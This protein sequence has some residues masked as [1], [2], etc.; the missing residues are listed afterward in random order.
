MTSPLALAQTATSTST[1]A[2][3]P[4]TV[5]PTGVTSAV[6]STPPAAIAGVSSA[7]A[8]SPAAGS[9]Q[10][11]PP[12]GQTAGAT[13]ASVAPAPPSVCPEHEA[14][15]AVFSDSRRGARIT[16]HRS[17]SSSSPA[18]VTLRTGINTFGRVVFRV[19]GEEGDFYR[20]ASPSRPNGSVGFV[21]KDQMSTYH[22]PFRV[23][24]SLSRR[25]LSAYR[26]GALILST[27]VAVGTRKAPTP[28]GSF[29]LVDLVRPS[30]GAGGPYGPF[31]FG[32]SGFSKVYQ[33]FGGG[34][35]RIGI[36][37]T[38]QPSKL[39]TAA[40]SGCIRVDNATITRLARTLYLGTPVNITP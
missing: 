26:C 27:R 12:Q 35:G 20:V 25:V 28:T 14:M 7:A 29:F 13:P 30:R 23:D 10:T 5:P 19:L 11:A 17:A 32:I 22:T 18:L 6:I 34:D 2:S 8:T 1:P 33:R 37:G 24:V 38:N 39:G 4:V 36:H 15:V 31:A 16:V 3:A 9:G 40:S 21:R